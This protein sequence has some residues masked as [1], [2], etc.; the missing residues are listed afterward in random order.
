[1]H[2]HKRNFFRVNQTHCARRMLIHT[3]TNEGLVRCLLRLLLL[4]PSAHCRLLTPSFVGVA[5]AAIVCGECRT[6][7]ISRLLGYSVLIEEGVLKVCIWVCILF[8]HPF[9]LVLNVLSFFGSI[10]S[11]TLSEDLFMLLWCVH[12]RLVAL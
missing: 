1:M 6:N 5:H 11:C 4:G 2:P 12:C 8:V 3:W 7:I 9:P 10:F